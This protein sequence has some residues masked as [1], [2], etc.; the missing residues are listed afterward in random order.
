MS[1]QECSENLTTGSASH[2]ET[3]VG[4]LAG[5]AKPVNL[6][7]K[8]TNKSL[9]HILPLESA[10][11]TRSNMASSRIPASENEP[12][13]GNTTNT[14]GS[15]SHAPTF[16]FADQSKSR[17]MIIPREL[18]DMIYGHVFDYHTGARKTATK[19]KGVEADLDRRSS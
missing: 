5:D 16:E 13:C 1:T 4:I 11:Q 10:D 3:S 2:D 15:P 17:L 18:R 12:A 7:S 6:I 8:T 19:F 14:N 9:T